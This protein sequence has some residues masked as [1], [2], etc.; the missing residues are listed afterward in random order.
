MGVLLFSLLK[1]VVDTRIELDAQPLKDYL[2]MYWP[3]AL[4]SGWI[5][6]AFIANFSAYLTK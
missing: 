1:I 4:Y 6:V 5:T 2:L 3:F